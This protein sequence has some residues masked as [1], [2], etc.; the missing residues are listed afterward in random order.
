[1]NFCPGPLQNGYP[2]NEENM[3][4][5]ERSDKSMSEG[6]QRE[7]G[8]YNKMDGKKYGEQKTPQDTIKSFI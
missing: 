2:Q 1:M 4:D 7:E 3:V 6:D 8:C 5:L